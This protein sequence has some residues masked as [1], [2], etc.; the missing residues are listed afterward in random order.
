VSVIEDPLYS[1]VFFMVR[2]SFPIILIIIQ[3]YS[4]WRKNPSD[5]GLVYPKIE[6]F[7]CDQYSITMNKPEG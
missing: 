5:I 4:S 6:G 2:D 7:V 1:E 3:N